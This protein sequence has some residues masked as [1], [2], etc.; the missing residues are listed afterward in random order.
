MI[1]QLLKG[2]LCHEALPLAESPALEILNKVLIQC[3][4]SAGILVIV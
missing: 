4:D 2:G 3:G 1:E